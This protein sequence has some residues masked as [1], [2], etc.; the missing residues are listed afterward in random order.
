MP[1][2]CFSFGANTYATIPNPVPFQ[3]GLWLEELSPPINHSR[4]SDDLSLANPQHGVKQKKSEVIAL[5]ASF[6]RSFQLNVSEK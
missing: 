6:D 2:I 4:L 5:L 3:L 1:D